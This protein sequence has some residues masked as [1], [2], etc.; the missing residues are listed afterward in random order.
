MGVRLSLIRDNWFGIAMTLV[1]DLDMWNHIPMEKQTTTH[2]HLLLSRLMLTA[3]AAHCFSVLCH[4]EQPSVYVSVGYFT[5]TGLSEK[6]TAATESMNWFMCK[7]RAALKLQL[8]V[9]VKTAKYHKTYSSKQGWWLL[10]G[11]CSVFTMV[12]THS[13]QSFPHA[14]QVSSFW[15]RG[16]GVGKEG[17]HW[18]FLC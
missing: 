7:A 9:N 12:T 8:H 2:H 3:I 6:S 14:I 4:S 13:K 17:L 11:V 5:S 1:S 15:K 16:V 18:H 10:C